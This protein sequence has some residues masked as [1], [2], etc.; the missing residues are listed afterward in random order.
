MEGQDEGSV[1]NERSR[2]ETTML[3]R[4]TVSGA[5]SHNEA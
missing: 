1:L 4:V 5:R 3:E 2:G